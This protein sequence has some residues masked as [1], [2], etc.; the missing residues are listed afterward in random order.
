M[1]AQL[2]PVVE[3]LLAEGETFT[4][5]SVERLIT[6]AGI[7]RSTFYVYFEDKGALLLALAEDVVAQLVGAAEQWWQLPPD[8]GEL[9]V[10]QVLRGLIDVYRRHSM[11]WDSLVDASSYDPKV[12][13]AFG[14]VVGTAVAGLAKHIRDGQKAGSVRE[15]IDPKRTAQWLT[16]MTERGLY[17]LTPDASPTELD[18]LCR[19]QTDIVWQT[20]Y[21]GSPSRPG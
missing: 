18:R 13:T 15:Q 21:A 1:V 9:D 5:I 10:E 4:S 17:Q 16:W 6:G 7:S 14:E 8:A 20:L 19:A 12:R 11:V 2:L 3:E